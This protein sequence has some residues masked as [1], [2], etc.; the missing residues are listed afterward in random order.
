MNDWCFR[1]DVSSVECD[2]A[3]AEEALQGR[4][5]MNLD[6]SIWPL[7]H[8]YPCKGNPMG[9]KLMNIDFTKCTPSYNGC[10]LIQQQLC[11]KEAVLLM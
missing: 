6:Y 8:L 7:L 11:Y 4:F 9:G 10:L 3:L 1:T 5:I 2:I